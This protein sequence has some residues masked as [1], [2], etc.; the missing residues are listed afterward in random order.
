MQD[1]R[2]TKSLWVLCCCCWV[3]SVAANTLLESTQAQQ[4][5]SARTE[6]GNRV[7]VGWSAARTVKAVL[8]DLATFASVYGYTGGFILQSGTAPMSLGCR[9]DEYIEVKP[10]KF[11]NGKKIV[12]GKWKHKT[13][14]DVDLWVPSASF[15]ELS[16]KVTSKGE[17]S[18]GVPIKVPGGWEWPA[19]SALGNIHELDVRDGQ[20]VWGEYGVLN[21]AKN[22]VYT[23][24]P[25]ELVGGNTLYILKCQQLVQ[26]KI[27]LSSNTPCERAHIV[28][29]D[30]PHI[31]A[32]DAE[33]EQYQADYEA[34]VARGEK[35]LAQDKSDIECIKALM[36]SG[37]CNPMVFQRSF[38]SRLGDGFFD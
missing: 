38:L 14:K 22:I 2:P 17:L 35:K 37:D 31:E 7:E 20:R 26:Q 27:S 10:D 28:D 5:L 19:G 25:Q 21:Y 16:D 8:Q 3:F 30:G 29:C 13:L 11:I 6:I 4:T 24:I 1:G 34:A 15:Q 9:P 32:T 18:A 12:Q 36:D 33:K 23:G